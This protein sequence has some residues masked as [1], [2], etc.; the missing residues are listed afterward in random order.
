M[1]TI[2]KSVP[3]NSGIPL[4]LSYIVPKIRRHSDKFPP[5]PINSDEFSEILRNKKT[6]MMRLSW[7]SDQ[8]R[9]SKSKISR[10]SDVGTKQDPSLEQ[11][12]GNTYSYQEHLYITADSFQFRSRWDFLLMPEYDRYLGA[13]SLVQVH[14][15]GGSGTGIAFAMFNIAE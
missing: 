9:S 10:N 2:A 6:I 4:P 1:L 11:R 7:G 13:S 5:T 12:V 8:Q 3:Y 14:A 15:S